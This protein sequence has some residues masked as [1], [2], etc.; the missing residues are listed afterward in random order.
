LALPGGPAGKSSKT[1][2]GRWLLQVFVLTKFTARWSVLSSKC[3]AKTEKS[4]P[5]ARPAVAARRENRADL[6]KNREKCEKATAVA[7]A[8]LRRHAQKKTLGSSQGSEV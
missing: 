5:R 6:H 4:F 3:R 8:G 1:T 7:T 2:S